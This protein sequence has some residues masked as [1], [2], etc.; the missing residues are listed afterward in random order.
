MTRRQSNL[1]W[2]VEQRLEF[3]EFR[4]YWEGRIN[5]GDLMRTFGVSVNQAS[6]DLNRYLGLAPENMIYD[7]SAR[8]YLPSAMFS[9]LFLKLDSDRYLTQLRSVD[10]GLL[11]AENA[12]LMHYPA[13]D[14][15]PS[16]SRVV[17]PETLRAVLAS[18]REKQSIEVRYQ[19]IARPTP[20]W[21]WI[22]PHALGFDGFRWHARA[23]CEDDKTYKDFLLAR[24]IETRG[25]RPAAC[26]PQDDAD[27]QEFVDLQI[28]PHPDLSESQRQVIALDYGMQDG[29][30][31]LRVRKAFLFYTLRRLGLDREAEAMHP[32]DQHI[33][34]LNRETIQSQL[35]SA[36]QRESA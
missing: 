30:A 31:D 10:E 9:P 20:R 25:M 7:K 22:A 21:R 26:D 32:A 1:R 15:A 6:T 4:L 34:L 17:N 29:R 19:S 33:V 35:P 23:F 24:I 8:S 18:L 12:W 16:P 3:I 36:D 28:G 13:Y 5:R 14:G 11:S 27:W 2:G